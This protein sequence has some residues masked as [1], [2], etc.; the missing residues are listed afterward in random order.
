MWKSGQR[1]IVHG[2]DAHKCIVRRCEH[3]CHRIIA[4]TQRAKFKEAREK[5]PEGYYLVGEKIA[6]ISKA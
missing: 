1:V 3:E 5:L 6:D 2:H 4:V